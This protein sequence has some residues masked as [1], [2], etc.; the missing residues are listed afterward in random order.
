MVII[1]PKHYSLGLPKGTHYFK[2][3]EI[4]WCL[5]WEY[6]LLLAFIKS[7]LIHKEYMITLG[8]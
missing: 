7:D 2:L 6:L 4:L 5:Y 1:L 8:F 3:H